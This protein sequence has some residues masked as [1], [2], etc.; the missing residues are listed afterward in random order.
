MRKLG[1]Y[2]PDTVP[3]WD[4]KKVLTSNNFLRSN[5][6]VYIFNLWTNENGFVIT[7]QALNFENKLH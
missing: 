1:R 2:L 6:M 7:T 5:S 3:D 4:N